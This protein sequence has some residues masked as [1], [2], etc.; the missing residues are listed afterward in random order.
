MLSRDARLVVL[1]AAEGA[2]LDISAV[3]DSG[4]GILSRTKRPM[5]LIISSAGATLHASA[6]V[7]PLALS[8]VNSGTITMMVVVGVELA[9]DRPPPVKPAVLGPMYSDECQFLTKRL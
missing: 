8:P 7:A 1:R 9:Q 3:P 6:V 5:P 4:I 2:V